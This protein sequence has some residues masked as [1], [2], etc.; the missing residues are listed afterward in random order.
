MKTP[1]EDEIAAGR[2]RFVWYALQHGFQLADAEDL[3]Q[4]AILKA[5]RPSKVR[6]NDLH[7]RIS[8][9][10]KGCARYGISRLSNRHSVTARRA[11]RE[12]DREGLPAPHR[13]TAPP[14][15]DPARV[16]EQ[17][18]QVSFRRRRLADRLGIT[19]Q[20]L[21]RLACGVAPVDPDEV[22]ASPVVTHGPGYTP[23]TEGCHGL[24]GSTDPNDTRQA[25]REEVANEWRRV[26]GL[27]P[28]PAADALASLKQEGG[29]A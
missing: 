19:P 12:R 2:R 7:H 15:A 10:L 22:S 27:P 5:L 17:V 29:A 11:Q 20:E 23:P 9:M 6:A 8:I 3:A 28:L 16:A 24:V 21:A 25:S 26:A 1:T 13:Q 18:E 4:D 14:P